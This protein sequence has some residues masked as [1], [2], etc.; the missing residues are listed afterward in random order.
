[1]KRTT[2]NCL[3]IAPMFIIASYP[4]FSQKFLA[5]YEVA[6]E[7]VLRSIPEEFIDN[8]RTNFVVAFQHTS[9]GTR[10]SR[11]LFGLQDY[12]AGDDVLFGISLAP[13]ESKLEFR[14]YA[15][16]SYAPEGID[17]SDLSRDETAFIQTTRNY[18][19]APEN[20]SVNVVMWSWCNIAGHEPAKNYLPG[21]DSLIA[22]YSEGGSKIGTGEG[23]REVPVTFIFMTGHA[24]ENANVGDY[25]PK[26]QAALITEHCNTNGYFC[27]DYY[28][29]DSHDM[30]DNYWEDV[31]DDGNSGEYGGNFYKDWQDEHSLGVDYFENKASPGGSVAFGSH[32]TQHITANR[33][34]YAMWW[35][36]ARIAGWN[37]NMAAIPVS[38]INVIPDGNVTEIVAGG[39]I[40]FSTELLPADAMNKEIAWSVT[41]LTGQG[42][43]TQDGLFTAEAEGSVSIM[44]T[45]QDGSGV[46]GSAQIQINPVSTSTEIPEAEG[47]L[48]YP[49]PGK[50][51]FNIQNRRTEINYISIYNTIGTEVFSLKPPYGSTV[52][53][54]DLTRFSPG[55]YVF[56][57]YLNS[58][59]VDKKAIILP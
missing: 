12:K 45:S 9:H 1:M 3:L 38:S 27:L 15:I 35:I 4:S 52:N 43:I 13:D 2:I 37:G 20:S 54:I 25:N 30:D 50:G 44:A 46:A 36:L 48:I 29:I 11:G 59:F 58:G 41:N 40:Q 55:M 32:T 7:E 34:G 53:S 16:S 51:I 42:S 31:G 6:K 39:N 33:K 21:M 8:A 22:E 17:A 23:Q 47:L 19:A 56:R 26:A 18:L 49:N 5:D 24:N 10:V 57:L 14:D 28:S